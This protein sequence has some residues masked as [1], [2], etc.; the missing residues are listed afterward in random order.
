MGEDH[1]IWRSSSMPG[2]REIICPAGQSTPILESDSAP[3]SPQ[4]QKRH[5][6]EILAHTLL[7]LLDS[8]R[9]F[10]VSIFQV[11]IS[12]ILRC[13]RLIICHALCE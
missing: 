6:Q 13:I 2:N 4:S 8:C 7:L 5:A 11:S 3:L 10:L 12:G 9:Y 1:L